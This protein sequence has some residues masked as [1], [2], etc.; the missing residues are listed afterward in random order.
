MNPSAGEPSKKTY[1]APT[2]EV[3]GNIQALTQAVGKSS[4]RDGGKINDRSRF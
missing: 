1:H 3:Y 4:R 2:I